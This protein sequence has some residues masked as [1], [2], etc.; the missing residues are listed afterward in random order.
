MMRWLGIGAIGLAGGFVSGLFGVGGG[1]LFVPLLVL[2]LNVD[3]HLAIGTSLAAII[4]TALTGALRHFSAHAIDFRIAFLMALFA[5]IGAW[6]GAGISLRMEVVLLRKLYALF[7]FFL[8]L[9][10]FFER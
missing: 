5:I 1:V 4:P 7:L 10:L 8:A 9:R 6:L 3:I 2:L